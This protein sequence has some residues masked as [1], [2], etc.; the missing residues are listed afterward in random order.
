MNDPAMDRRV[1]NIDAALGHHL[2]E[3]P[4]TEAVSQI[5]AHA[6]QDHRAVKM[7]VLQTFQK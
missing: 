4:Q 6:Q 5:P 7:V 3:I 2:F 1:I